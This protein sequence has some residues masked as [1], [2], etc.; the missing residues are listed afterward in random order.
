MGEGSYWPPHPIAFALTGSWVWEWLKF[1]INFLISVQQIWSF[2]TFKSWLT[3]LQG[4]W[5][6]YE[7]QPASLQGW[8]YERCS[9]LPKLALGLNGVSLHWRL[10]SYPSPY[11][12]HSLQGYPRELVRSSETDITLDDV[13]TL[14]DEHYNNVKTLDTL[15]QE[16]F[17][18]WMGEK[19][20]VFDWGCICWDIS[21]FVQHPSQNAFPWTT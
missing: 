20:T 21:R 7:D 16:L 5:K 1:S 15:N 14:L 4:V 12:I 6:P 13:L 3:M 11:A 8:R 19:E 18:L 10:R 17:Q 2:L 9:H